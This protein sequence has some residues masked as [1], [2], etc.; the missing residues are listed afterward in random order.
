MLR[1]KERQRQNQRESAIAFLA[2][3]NWFL[4]RHLWRLWSTTKKLHLSPLPHRE[5][6]THC[7][8]W[9][10]RIQNKKKEDSFC[11]LLVNHPL[12]ACPAFVLHNRCGIIV[13]GACIR[14]SVANI[15]T[16]RLG[17]KTHE[18]QS[19]MVG[20][21]LCIDHRSFHF[22]VHWVLKVYETSLGGCFTHGGHW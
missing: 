15:N 19:T 21:I 11:C 13:T 17:N 4:L 20:L 12:F 14:L 6:R 10:L 18:G 5:P 16:W 1:R 7:H 8:Y 22:C 3:R 2:I 9:M